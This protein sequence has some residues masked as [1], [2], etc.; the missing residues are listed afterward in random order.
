MQVRALDDSVNLPARS[1]PL[2][3]LTHTSLLPQVVLYHVLHHLHRHL[4]LVLVDIFF[5]VAVAVCDEDVGHPAAEIAKLS[6]TNFARD[7]SFLESLAFSSFGSGLV[8]KGASGKNEIL[9][10]QSFHYL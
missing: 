7:L 8:R 10:S 2:P 6:T 1:W 5:A 9:H 3:T 4:V